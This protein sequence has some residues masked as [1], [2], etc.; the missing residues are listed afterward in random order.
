MNT[1]DML[2]RFD[3]CAEALEWVAQQSDQSPQALWDACPRGDW[4]LWHPGI[5]PRLAVLAGAE[6]VRH[7]LPYAGD[8]YP[9]ALAW[10]ETAEAF[11]RGEATREQLN[12]QWGWSETRHAF[13]VGDDAYDTEGAAAA[14]LLA[15]HDIIEA[16]GAYAEDSCESAAGFFAASAAAGA[17]LAA[18]RV[19]RDYARA[20]GAVASEH[21]AAEAAAAATHRV[22]ADAVRAIIP[23]CP[24]LPE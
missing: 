4:L 3:P 7:A 24:E 10:I 1:L 5:E 12:I 16:A 11:I 6:C 22:C 13:V 14:A 15:A 17:A 20:V 23:T 2:R 21:A 19:V 18:A 8:A 9:H